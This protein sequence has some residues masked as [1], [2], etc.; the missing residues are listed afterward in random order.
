MKRRMKDMKGKEHA[1]QQMT[2]AKENQR[3]KT[4]YLS[5]LTH[6]GMKEFPFYPA[7]LQCRLWTAFGWIYIHKSGCDGELGREFDVVP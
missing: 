6:S 7:L 3:K 1:R 2:K 4:S 5:V